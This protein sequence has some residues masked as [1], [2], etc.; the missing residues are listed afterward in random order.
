M[1]KIFVAGIL[2]MFALM[3]SAQGQGQGR[4]QMTP[5]QQ[6]QQYETMKKDLSLT[7][8][9]LDE[10]KKADEE[11]RTKMQSLR[12]S[13]GGD[14]EAMMAEMTKLTEARNAKVK[15]QLSAEQY[16]KYEA[17]YGRAFGG[18]PGGGGN[19]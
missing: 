15:A 5:E 1:K 12:D 9:Q 7:D 10:I 6:A 8:T 11:M 4:G 3:V 19:R 17:A 18:R 13:G 2:L 16:T 14:R